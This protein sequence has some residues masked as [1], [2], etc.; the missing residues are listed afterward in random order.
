MRRRTPRIVPENERS[1]PVQPSLNEP[2][3]WFRG[4]SHVTADWVDGVSTTIVRTPGKEPARSA[5]RSSRRWFAPVLAVCVLLLTVA[6]G[7]QEAIAATGHPPGSSHGAVVPKGWKSST[8]EGV[9]VSV[10]SSWTVKHAADC[11]NTSAPGALLLGESATETNCPMYHYPADQVMIRAI[12]VGDETGLTHGQSP[13]I[14]NGIRVFVL[15]GS[16]VARE[17]VAPSRGIEISGS[18]PQAGRV[19][20]T[21]RPA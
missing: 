9:T 5:R 7:A 13:E 3:W 4:L 21:L 12:P 1:G 6:V 20:H 2:N 14:I 17:W 11:P 18:G 8:Y 19:V 15:F 10:P 16:P